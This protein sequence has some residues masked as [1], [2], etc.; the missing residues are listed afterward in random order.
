MI[1]I[2]YIININMINMI[3]EASQL[4]LMILFMYVVLFFFFIEWF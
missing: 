3:Q 1:N 2:N 4:L